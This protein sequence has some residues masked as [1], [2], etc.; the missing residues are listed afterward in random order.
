MTAADVFDGQQLR[1][2]ASAQEYRSVFGW[3]VEADLVA[4]RLLLVEPD[5][6]ARPAQCQPAVVNMPLGLARKVMLS[7]EQTGML[8]PAYLT[9]SE[10]LRGH[11][12]VDGRLGMSPSSL[13]WRTVD[14]RLSQLPVALPLPPSVSVC[15]AG[16]PAPARADASGVWL[17][18]PTLGCSLPTV[19]QFLSAVAQA[20][21]V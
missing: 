2:L 6:E 8:P 12:V 10:H 21:S 3:P 18:L 14:L 1:L 20:I 4:M 13:I 19:G 17:R 15:S 16:Q 9:G 11:L 5:G 7:L